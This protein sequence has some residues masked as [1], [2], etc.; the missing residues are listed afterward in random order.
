MPLRDQLPLAPLLIVDDNEAI[1]ESI[2]LLLEDAGYTILEA[3]NGNDAL[4]VLRESSQP[5]VVLLDDRMPDLGGEEVLR[6]VLRD[7]QL[8]RRHTFILLS[9]QPHLSRR[10]RLQRL[11]QALAIEVV[12]K[13]FD[14]A[15]LDEAVVRAQTRQHNLRAFRLPVPRWSR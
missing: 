4:T 2:R 13:P 7:R 6:A 3:S 9:G 10:L 11:L 14:V 8:R 1:R 12:S 5:L 15:D